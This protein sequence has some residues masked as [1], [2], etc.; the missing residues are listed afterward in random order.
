[1]GDFNSADMLGWLDAAPASPRN[2]ELLKGLAAVRQGIGDT[3]LGADAPTK[4]A[5]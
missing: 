4:S 1:M 3:V 2:S 5:E